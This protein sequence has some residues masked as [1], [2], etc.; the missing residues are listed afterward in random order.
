MQG[1]NPR[2]RLFI[3]LARNILAAS[4]MCISG[5]LPSGTSL[6]A[7]HPTSVDDQLIVPI[8]LCV[9]RGIARTATPSGSF[10][11][12]AAICTAVL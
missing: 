11:M 1:G 10:S 5:M 12:I 6:T 7:G 3:A 4:E 2:N 9:W 8:A